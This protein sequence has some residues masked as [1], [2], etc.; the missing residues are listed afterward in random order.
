MIK[1]IEAVFD[2]EVFFPAEPIAL[3]PNT[4]V[5]IIIE[6]LLS[7]EDEIIPFLQTALSLNLEGPSDWSANLDDYLYGEKTLND[8]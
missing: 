6:T 3:K 7:N 5:K 2:G 1:T 4:R 8:K